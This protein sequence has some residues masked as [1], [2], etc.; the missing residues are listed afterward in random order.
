MSDLLSKPISEKAAAKL[1][2]FVE[3][4]FKTLM[5]EDVDDKAGAAKAKAIVALQTDVDIIMFGVVIMVVL[6]RGS[7]YTP[8]ISSGQI[9]ARKAAEEI[10]QI[11]ERARQ[12]DRERHIEEMR[13]EGHQRNGGE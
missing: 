7:E 6:T 11:M 1:V 13:R 3:A 4:Y 10:V 9:S 12:I 2:D 8:R 5:A